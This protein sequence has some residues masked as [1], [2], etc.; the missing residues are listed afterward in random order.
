MAGKCS[1]YAAH[2]QLERF[3]LVERNILNLCANAAELG[4]Y[5]KK[6]EQKPNN[7]PKT[8]VKVK[9]GQAVIVERNGEFH[10]VLLAGTHILVP[11]KDKV[12]KF[13]AGTEKIV[14]TTVVYRMTI[15]YHEIKSYEEVPLQI[16]CVAEYKV[17]N[18]MERVYNMGDNFPRP[19]EEAIR[20]ALQERA[21]DLSL[22]IFCEDTSCMDDTLR[23]ANRA[24]Q[25]KHL[26][27]S[28]SSLRFTAL[29]PVGQ[30]DREDRIAQLLSAWNP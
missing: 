7:M 20:E 4:R 22:K 15:T 28:I 17:V 11:F 16:S 9:E 2:L 24:A 25:R 10:R 6:E 18:P 23:L 1:S 12:K 27:V 8:S 5:K 13:N 29:R 14:D 26:G 30:G 21:Q 3:S 19:V